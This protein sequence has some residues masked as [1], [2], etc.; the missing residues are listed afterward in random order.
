MRNTDRIWDL[1][2]AK[3]EAFEQLA[4]RVWEIP[5][6]A[7]TEHG[8]VAEHTA[9]LRRQGFRV[10]ENVADIPTAV[11]GPESPD[12]LKALGADFDIVER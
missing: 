12:M 6:I 8:S 5:E 9:M 7:Y 11:V 2:D 3:R 4:D 10:R 1:V